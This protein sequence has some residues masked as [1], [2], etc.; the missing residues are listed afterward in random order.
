MASGKGGTGKTTV[1]VSLALAWREVGPVQLVDCDVEEPNDHL[2]LAPELS[3][4]E[5]V[6]LPVPQVD[7][8]KC[9]RCR[10]CSEAC[11]YGALAV[12]DRGVL[13][14]PEL[15]HGCGLCALVCPAG[16]IEEV[17]R[18]IGWVERGTGKGLVFLRGMLNVGEPMA[19]PI[20]ERLKERAASDC[21]TI[22]DLP[23]GTGC[24]VIAALRGADF[25]L[26]VTEPTPFG[27]HDLQAAVGVARAV[28]TPVGVIISRHG[29]GGDEVERYCR[30]QGLPVLLRIPMDRRIAASYARGIALVEAY[31]DWREPFIALHAGIL[32]QVGA[33]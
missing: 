10:A 24:P 20:V 28:G 3:Q 14:S 31:P 4:R 17:P 13:L 5:P 19:T 16:A 23:P 22:M 32:A 25:A 18:T 11:R 27:L 12:I 7:E 8:A 9:T 1:A 29:I 15:C 26:L 33:M 30:E 2:F 6:E 21:L